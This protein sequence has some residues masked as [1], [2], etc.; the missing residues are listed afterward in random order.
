LSS[1]YHAHL[2]ATHG[3]A[4]LSGRERLTRTA[5]T[6]TRTGRALA[7]RAVK[8][9]AALADRVRPPGRG[10][11]VLSYH[12]VGADSGLEVDLPVGLFEAQMS[13]LA[14]SGRVSSLG[15]ALHV[16]AC[17]DPPPRDPVVVTFDDGTADFAERALPV[18]E[19]HRV[20]ATLYVATDYVERR[21][22]FPHDGVPISWDALRDTRSS[23]L[24]TVGSHTHTHAVMDRLSLAEAEDEVERS[25]GL[26]EER[27]GVP[28]LDFAYPKGVLG[29]GAAQ[30]AVRRRFRSAALARVGP[31][32]Y[33]R[34]DP[35]LL[36]RSPIQAGDGMR[37][38][39]RKV[40]GGLAL[41][42]TLRRVLNGRRYSGATT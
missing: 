11:V 7:L 21:Q 16:L 42:G 34:T 20:P 39:V 19:R 36:T 12:R 2:R 35:H 3:G 30:T 8:A 1:Q 41:E 27:L 15:D 31:N 9:S 32:P 6:M 25:A 17:A 18:L 28:A 26:V 24:I 37:W 13:F 38:F 23:G 29:S 4:P 40:E 5:T 14:A 33:G 10:V 22:R